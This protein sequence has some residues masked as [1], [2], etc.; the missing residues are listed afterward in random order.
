MK[1]WINYAP[2]PPEAYLTGLISAYISVVICKT[3]VFALIVP[4][5]FFLVIAATIVADLFIGEKKIKKAMT[6]SIFLLAV[7]SPIIIFVCFKSHH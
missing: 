6:Q 7:L 4:L 5:F 3:L 1:D 2:Y